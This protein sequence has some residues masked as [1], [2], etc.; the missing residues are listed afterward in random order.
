MLGQ[1]GRPPV[2]GESIKRAVGWGVRSLLETFVAKEDLGRALSIYRQHHAQALKSTTSWLPGAKDLVKTLKA[3]GYKLAIASNRPTRFTHI[4]LKHLHVDRAFDR[5]LCADRVIHPKPN[6]EMLVKILADCSLEPEE[7]LYVGDMTID[8]ETGHAA[9]VKTVAVVTGSS[10]REEMAPLKPFAIVDR[11]ME[12]AGILE[13]PDVA[14][15]SPKKDIC[16]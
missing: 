9:G 13:K 4:I 10:R 11:V 14:A 3:R 12:V 16:C 2:D 7:A 1:M 15:P 6:P 8:I 5:V